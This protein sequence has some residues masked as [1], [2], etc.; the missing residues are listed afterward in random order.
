MAGFGHLLPVENGS[1][2]AVHKL[3][4][5]RCW[6][7]IAIWRRVLLESRTIFTGAGWSSAPV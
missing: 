5:A 1:F 3:A 7:R 4:V 2:G 6:L